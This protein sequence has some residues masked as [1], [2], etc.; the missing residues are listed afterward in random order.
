MRSNEVIPGLSR[1]ALKYEA[2]MKS[3][4]ATPVASSCDKDEDH[5]QL[6]SENSLAETSN[7]ES[8]I[9]DFCCI[10]KLFSSNSRSGQFGQD[11]SDYEKSVSNTPDSS[12]TFDLTSDEG[13]NIQEE[14]WQLSLQQKLREAKLGEEQFYYDLSLHATFDTAL[15]SLTQTYTD[16]GFTHRLPR[17]QAILGA[18]QPFSSV[19][20]TMV[21]SNP[22][23]ASLVW[24]SIQLIL[25]VRQFNKITVDDSLMVFRVS[26]GIQA[27]SK[28][29]IA[30][31]MR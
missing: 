18:I 19:I 14:L 28:I 17:V 30:C 13:A 23:I 22:T 31:Y 2:K 7:E 3:F 11:F 20:T 6:L 24:G 5:T 1:L 15:S 4:K 27:S 10:L 21:Q 9:M 29:S 25:K 12:R 16:N 8:S 26:C